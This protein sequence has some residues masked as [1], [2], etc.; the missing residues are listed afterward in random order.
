MF[1]I[2][3]GSRT[4]ILTIGVG[5]FLCPKCHITQKFGHKQQKR[6]FTLYYIPILPI[7]DGQ[8]YVE[9]QHCKGT[10]TPEVLRIP[11][12][13]ATYQQRHPLLFAYGLIAAAM[14]ALMVIG[15]DRDDGN[16]ERANWYR[17]AASGTSL[18]CR[19]QH[20][21]RVRHQFRADY[22]RSL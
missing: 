14:I 9:C 2:I 18:D 10:F 12:L 1:F 16:R 21:G 15:N 20:E 19:V 6:F 4:I 22:P 5:T 8:Q 7:A 3:W 11:Q 17:S 13:Q